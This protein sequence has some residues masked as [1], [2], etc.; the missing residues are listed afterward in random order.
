MFF[1][2]N[3][4][5]SSVRRQSG[6]FIQIRPRVSGLVLCFACRF[7][8]LFGIHSRD[9]DS[10]LCVGDDNNAWANAHPSNRCRAVHRFQ[11][12]PARAHA[13]GFLTRVKPNLLFIKILVAVCHGCSFAASVLVD[14]NAM[15]HP[16]VMCHRT[17]RAPPS[18]LTC[19]SNSWAGL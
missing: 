7:C 12:I 1:P 17:E 6:F 14:G 11:F 13:M 8:E 15:L 4:V 3:F 2:F 9:D 5:D 16:R 10:S 19:E 18:S